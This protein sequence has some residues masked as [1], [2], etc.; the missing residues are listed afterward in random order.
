MLKEMNRRAVDF[1][2]SWRDENDSRQ[3][4]NQLPHSEHEKR[5]TNRRSSAKERS[6]FFCLDWGSAIEKRSHGKSSIKGGYASALWDRSKD[7]AGCKK[8]D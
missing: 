3:I 6:N 7:I 1:M 5:T 2:K 4:Q 8:V